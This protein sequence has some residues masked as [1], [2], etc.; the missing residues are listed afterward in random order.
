MRG[1]VSD[2]CI[3][4]L[5]RKSSSPRAWGCFG[6]DVRALHGKAVFPTCVGV[7]P[8]P[9]HAACLQCRL[10]HVRGGVSCRDAG[11]FLLGCVFPTC[12]GVFP[13]RKID[14]ARYIS[15]PHVRG[16][17]SRGVQERHGQALSS[18]RAWGC[19]ERHKHLVDRGGVFPTCVGVFLHD[20]R[21]CLCG[22]RLP[23]VRG[24]VSP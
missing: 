21:H 18:P 11:E 6:V 23:H 9:C 10:P 19:F 7:F 12:V 15:L 5:L 16:G 8:P 20:L 1:G 2:S 22:R 14:R 17:V 13:Q 4:L 3:S 24:G